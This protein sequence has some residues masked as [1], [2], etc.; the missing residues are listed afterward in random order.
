MKPRQS[1]QQIINVLSVLLCT[2]WPSTLTLEQ[3]VVVV[4]V[5]HPVS[6]VSSVPY[7]AGFHF[8]EDTP[9]GYNWFTGRPVILFIGSETFADR[10]CPSLLDTCS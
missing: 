8:L 1:R 5:H 9:T 4:V 3:A 6:I 10:I 2:E 7:Y